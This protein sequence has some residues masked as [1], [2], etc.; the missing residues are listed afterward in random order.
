MHPSPGPGNRFTALGTQLI[1]IHHWL[2]EELARLR[3]SLEPG[4]VPPNGGDRLRSLRAHCLSFCSALTAHHTGE[5][6]GAFRVL[7]EEAP[8][9]RPVLAKLA[10]DHRLI[11]GIVR[12]IE[13]LVAGPPAADP[14]AAARVLAE[15][16]GLTAIVESHFGFE[17]RAIVTAL[18][19]LRADAGTA[20]ELYGLA[21]PAW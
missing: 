8:Q 20:E 19:A 9:L 1:E 11:D 4:A 18:D 15:L 7:A 6:G 21:P 3:A 17:E 16:D 14:A 10:Q 2:R 13:E 5:D 12:R